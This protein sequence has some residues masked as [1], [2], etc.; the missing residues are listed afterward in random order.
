MDNWDTTLLTWRT[1]DDER[2]DAAPFIIEDLRSWFDT[3]LA[4]WA[5]RWY[6]KILVAADSTVTVNIWFTAA[7]FSGSHWIATTPASFSQ[8]RVLFLTGS[9]QAL[10]C[11]CAHCL[12]EYSD[13]HW[14]ASEELFALWL[15]EID[16][17]VTQQQW[18]PVPALATAQPRLRV[19]HWP[20]ARRL[21]QGFALGA[22]IST[23]VTFLPLLFAPHGGI[24]LRVMVGSLS[25]LVFSLPWALWP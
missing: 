24:P 2:R 19:G 3:H 22:A 13:H 23:L 16:T 25:V 7:P 17:V 14:H 12:L 11:A 20:P 4:A 8:G 21:A 1:Q 15:A 10:H 9:L 18:A 5:D 6:G